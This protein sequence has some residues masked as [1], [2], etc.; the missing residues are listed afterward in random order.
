M[1]SQKYAGW[2]KPESTGLIPGL[3]GTMSIVAVG[4]GAL[5]IGSAYLLHSMT[6][7]AVILV[8][9]VLLI[10][11]SMLRFQGTSAGDYFV[12]WARSLPI[13][14][15]LAHR[16]RTGLFAQVP[17]GHSR[18]PGLASPIILDRLFDP[19]TG[20]DIGA[21]VNT[22]HRTVTI[23]MMCSATGRGTQPE[24]ATNAQVAGWGEF[25]RRAG[26]FGDV[27]GIA[28]VTE[29]SP[30]T[31]ARYGV[32]I[33][34]RR[35]DHA[36]RRV[37]QLMES[38][39]G[40]P[41][42]PDPDE[43]I[44]DE[45]TSELAADR[46]RYTQR[47]AVTF[48]YSSGNFRSGIES[49]SRHLEQL[50]DAAAG[51]GLFATFATVGE[52]VAFTHAAFNP[53]AGPILDESMARTG[54]PGITWDD[55]GPTYHDDA[56]RYYIH[57]SG[58]SFT[59]RAYD[60]PV[61]PVEDSILENLLAPTHRAPYKRVTMIYRPYRP[62]DAIETTDSDYRD[63]FQAVQRRKRGLVDAR[64]QMRFDDI[65]ATRDDLAEGHGLTRVGMLVTVTV[66]VDASG[67]DEAAFI[68]G[69]GVAASTKFAACY[70]DQGAMFLSGLGIGVYP[71]MD[72][73][74]MADI[75]AA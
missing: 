58:K 33:D 63:A 16:Y 46:I 69:A 53:A 41:L 45:P 64:Q 32:E 35:H 75:L 60:F 39:T 55:A 65:A 15:R 67:V 13:R 28:A 71:D 44:A 31:G 51:A 36:P 62:Q 1:G 18:L 37:L 34:R 30:E 11:P 17:G 8:I 52:I 73:T 48:R 20:D 38:R 57:D 42:D 6:G 19:M 29:T 4:A 12:A 50:A 21:L 9:A 59:F 26:E 43:W 66:P 49:V 14:R 27:A 25:L 22:V 3:S 2:R 10:G 5:A 68:R 47:V 61:R 72:E 7:A 56:H 74:D 54:D 24:D 23:V 70:A 40:Y